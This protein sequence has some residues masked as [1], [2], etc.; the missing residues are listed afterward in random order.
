MPT[1]EHPP[2]ERFS[3]RLEPSSSQSRTT[4]SVGGWFGASR[5]GRRDVVVHRATRWTLGMVAAT[6]VGMVLGAAPAAAE[7]TVT[8]SEAVRGD[9]AKLTFRV[10][11]DRKPAYTT[12]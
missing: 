3:P 9:A 5:P 1:T 10:T 12:Q 2:A 7:V 11:E 6:L 4:W 8:P